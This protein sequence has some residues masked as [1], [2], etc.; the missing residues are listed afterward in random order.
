[1]DKLDLKAFEFNLLRQVCGISYSRGTSSMQANSAV[2]IAKAA[3][4]EQEAEVSQQLQNEFSLAALLDP[5]WAICPVASTF[6]EGQ[7]VLVYEDYQAE[8]LNRRFKGSCALEFFF[9][10]ALQ[11]TALL[12]SLHAAGL[13]HRDIKPATLLIDQE[14]I[15]RL[16]G[17]GFAERINTAEPALAVPFSSC[18]L[19]Y[20]SP[21]HTGLSADPVDC[22]SELYSVGVVLYELLTGRLPFELSETADPQDWMHCHLVCDVKEPHILTLGIPAWLS[23]LV[24]KLLEKDPE[25]RYQSAA[26]LEA[27]LLYCHKVWRETAD[28]SPFPLGQFHIPT[29]LHIPDSLYLRQQE[30]E[31][32]HSALHQSRVNQHKA[33]VFLTGAA[34]MGKSSLMQAFV[35]DLKVAG[36]SVAFGKAEQFRNDVPYITLIQAFRLCIKELLKRPAPEREFW[37]QRLE[38]GLVSCLDRAISLLPELASLCSAT[39]DNSTLVERRDSSGLVLQKLIQAIATSESPF[40]LV[41]DDI[42]WLDQ[43]SQNFVIQL[44]SEP[45]TLPLLLVLGGRDCGETA[46]FRAALTDPKVVWAYDLQLKPLDNAQVTKIIAGTFQTTHPKVLNLA[47]LV[48]AKTLGNPF[49]VTQFLKTLVQ[50]G[51]VS[52]EPY[53]SSWLCDLKAIEAIAYTDNVAQDIL[54]RYQLLAAET[55]QLLIGIACIGRQTELNFLADL[56]ELTSEEVQRRIQSALH[57]DVLYKTGTGYAF[58]HDLV[59]S[60]TKALISQEDICRF[61]LMIG[62]QLLKHAMISER[63]DELF[64][65]IEHLSLASALLTEPAERQHILHCALTAAQKA[66][67]T[68]SCQSALYFIRFASS[69]ISDSSQDH[70]QILASLRLEQA[71]CEMLTGQLEAVPVILAEVLQLNVGVIQNAQAYQLYTELCLRRSAY[72]DAVDVALKGLQVFDI[73][74]SP[75]PTNADCLRAYHQLKQRLEHD[76]RQSF[77]QL[78]L[79]SDPQ[80]EAISG[81]LAALSVPAS[82]TNENLHF[83][84]LCY[85]LELALDYGITGA[86]AAALGWFGVLIGHRYGEYEEGM[87]YC[88]LARSLVASH[89]FAGY[90]AKTL[91]T[92][93]QI[94]VWTQPLSFAIDCAH[95]G[96]SAGVAHGDLATAC[97]ASCHQVANVFSLGQPLDKAL[98]E[99]RR[100]LVFSKKVAFYDVELILSVQQ[101]FIENLHLGKGNV[102]SGHNLM[103]AIQHLS[104]D[105]L[106]DRMSTLVFWY[107]L[108]KGMSH[109]YAAEYQD[110]VFCLNKAGG[111]SWSAPAH[112]H[113]L[114]Y[115]FFSAMALMAAET[116]LSAEFRQKLEQHQQ[117]IQQWA[118]LNPTNFADKAAILQAELWRFDGEIFKAMTAFEAVVASYK[119]KDFIHYKALAFERAGR[120]AVAHGQLTAAAAYIQQAI[121]CYQQ[122]AAQSKV[123]QLEKFCI[124]S[125]IA[126]LPAS[127]APLSISESAS[128][129]YL[130]NLLRA[131]RAI[132]EQVEYPKLLQVLLTIIVEQAG[133]QRV[134]LL[135]LKGDSLIVEARAQTTTAGVIIETLHNEANWDDLP[136]SL[137]NTAIRTQ[138]LLHVKAGQQSTPYDLDPYFQRFSG[139]TALCLPM[140]RQGKLIAM[141]YI[142]LRAKDGQL[143]E[144]YLNVLKFL[145]AHAAVSIETTRLYTSVEEVNQQRLQLERALRV[146]DTSL[147]LGEQISRTGSWRWELNKNT[148]ICSEE[149]CRIFGLDPQRRTILFAD[150]AACI[151][152]DDKKSVLEKINRSVQMETAIKVEYRIVK[153][154]G[155]ILYLTG[156]GS[157]VF[158]TDKLI[159]YV[160]TVIDVTARRAS[161]D[162]LRAAQDDLARVSRITTIGQLTSSIA[163]EINQPLMSIV[164]NAGAGLRWLHRNTPDLQQV[165]AS[166]QAIATEGQ[167]AGQIVQSLR[168]LTKN[169]KAVLTVLDIHDVLNHIL[170]IAR[171][172]I[173]RRHVSLV[174][175]LDAQWSDILGDM[176]QLQQVMLNLVMNAIEAMSEVSDRPRV[177]TISTFTEEDQAIFIWVEDTGPGINNEVK[178]RLFDAFYTTKKDG[179]GMGLTICQ[180]IVEMHGGKLSAAA[181]QPVGTVFS[182]FLPLV[183]D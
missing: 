80:V 163:H 72:Q 76:F 129:R 79:M 51:L 178:D 110:A 100:G 138:K 32:L 151:H 13:L 158:G 19:A 67:R 143:N 142:E 167:R 66:K 171:S 91:L 35:A 12:K 133:A 161:E 14:G 18:S 95:A 22:R 115:H 112:I 150:F 27:D 46:V 96:F 176:V 134:L 87:A 166:L 109:Y 25:Q 4:T 26:A 164:A 118:E 16:S 126:E 174:L 33:V 130:S 124:D 125:G 50:K 94:S 73:V 119:N 20:I 175:H 97:F 140:I 61:D 149:F 93:D 39:P 21:E 169:T 42:Q 154:D 114:D 24:L 177:L 81:L 69:L 128:G 135:K 17:F 11:I 82:F 31:Q 15:I 168:A 52:R 83:I 43:A 30:A 132:T 153:A 44:I 144:E 59:H 117:K 160:G 84:Q 68:N 113:L 10:L 48:L 49:F 107:W 121:F 165:S 181:R 141:F 120:M 136:K 54:Q 75:A 157:P 34:G 70:K 170:A 29:S 155:S 182:F 85:A 89:Q 104:E 103:S 139:I 99:A 57:S 111:Y 53:T 77:L 58:F 108:Y 5:A 105:E 179:M 71:D 78:P 180:S 98:A 55:Q 40:V 183:K 148:L 63:D 47:P 162:A 137:I 1:M 123:R 37:Q 86:S 102:F 56:F 8:A 6:F 122:W 145:A 45:S 23:K 173:E 28:I 106:S 172:E 41:V 9:P 147:A 36:L 88:Q 38:H 159:D 90:E 127:S 146:A 92:L 116:E 2:V 62:R 65:A 152:P 60:A 3:T 131:S 101:A 156:Q 74:L 7:P 64:R